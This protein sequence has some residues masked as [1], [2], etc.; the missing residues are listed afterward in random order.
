M[1]FSYKNI[2]ISH[3][4][5]AVPQF[6]KDLHEYESIYGAQ[7]IK[8]IIANTGI[9]KV[10]I[11][12]DDITTSD[13]CAAAFNNILKE[14]NI[15]ISTID[16]LVF[17][18]QTPDYKLPQ[19]SIILQ[20]KL[21][22]SKETAC[23][24]IPLGCSGYIYGILQASMLV[25]SGCRRVLLLAGDTTTKIIDKN[26]RSVS[27]VFGD[28]GSATLIEPGI[29]DM[30]IKV[31]SDGSG[32]DKLIM[33]AG[34]CRSENN[35]KHNSIDNTNIVSESSDYLFMD[36]MAVM[37]FAIKEVPAIISEALSD[38][39]WSY[40]DV[41]FFALHQANAFMLNYLGKKMKIPKEKLPISVEGY[42][43]TG[44][45]SIPLLLSDKFHDKSESQ[46][47][48]KVI[49]C[50]FGV[51]LSWGTISTSLTGTN[52]YKPIMI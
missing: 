34:G 45:A 23:F 7:E 2:R 49:L 36:G 46:K 41:S 22:L 15:D 43:N 9:S 52:I 30:D 3:I 29:D 51:G 21:G 6:V 5:T 48:E 19:T 8:K 40:E 10:R 18:S 42:G 4:A 1:N 50:G 28:A 16:A 27:M 37:N 13:L 20:D 39:N 35:A 17:V 24:D 25:S 12:S 31:R 47:F 11:A 14:S 32:F 33:K 38:K 26:D 44:P